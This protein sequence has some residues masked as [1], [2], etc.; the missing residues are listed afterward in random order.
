MAHETNNRDGLLAR[1]RR[2]IRR[3]E[4]FGPEKR[5]GVV[6]PEQRKLR[7][8]VAKI[9]KKLRRLKKNEQAT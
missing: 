9:D 2:L 7:N 1:R 5:R 4:D 6:S 8:A 3:L